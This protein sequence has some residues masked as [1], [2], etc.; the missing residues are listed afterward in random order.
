MEA[1]KGDKC[2]GISAFRAIQE[3]FRSRN[4]KLEYDAV[5]IYIW[6]SENWRFAGHH[7]HTQELDFELFI[8]FVRYFNEGG[9]KVTI[10]FGQFD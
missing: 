10:A 9:E 7:L 8:T 2:F 5:R 1:P 3:V 6:Q 4:D